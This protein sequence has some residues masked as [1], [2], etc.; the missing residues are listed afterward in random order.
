MVV[1][2]IFK[3]I[4]AH[5]WELQAIVESNDV[6]HTIVRKLGK[7]I[8]QPANE[9]DIR[10]TLSSDIQEDFLEVLDDAP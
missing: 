4:S 8:G 1:W 6:M 3:R 2:L 10:Y 5:G 7:P 9:G